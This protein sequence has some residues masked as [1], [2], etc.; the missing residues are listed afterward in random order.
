MNSNQLSRVARKLVE[1]ALEEDLG[2][3]DVSTDTLISEN[4][5]SRARIVARQPLTL[6]GI[7]LVDEVFRQVDPRIPSGVQIADGNPLVPGD[8]V[9]EVR[10]STRSLLQGER[11]ALN[12]LQYLSGIAT[13]TAAFVKAAHQQGARPRICDTRKTTP[14]YRMLSKYAVRCGGGHN[15]RFSLA[16]VVM[17]KDNHIAVCGG[18]TQALENL[19]QNIPHTASVVVEADTLDQ[20]REAAAAK[21]EVI[22]LDNMT[23]EDMKTAVRELK[24]Q[25]LLEASGGITLESIGDIAQTGVD[26]ISVGSLTH[27]APAADL[28]LELE[29]IV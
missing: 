8:V 14:G 21:V 12:F 25:V 11:T 26:V 28:A 9:W 3:G 22:L 13:Q 24:G 10:A 7:N 20:A 15:H 18:I 23:L 1:L 16:D 5:Q 29:S 4:H 27:S 6:A 17:L 2:L 19:R